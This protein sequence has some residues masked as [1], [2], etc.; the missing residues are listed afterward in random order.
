MDKLMML[1]Y[2]LPFLTFFHFQ[3]CQ[4]LVTYKSTLPLNATSPFAGIRLLKESIKKDTNFTNGISICVRFNYRQLGSGTF[5]FAQHKPGTDLFVQAQSGYYESFFFFGKMNWI[6]KDMKTGSFLVWS[7]NRWHSI[8]VTF[9]RNTSHI[10]LVKV[11]PYLN[12]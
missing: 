11:S 1:S 9:D 3:T 4:T 12:I 8:C 10:T 2:I 7:T 6:L 5:I